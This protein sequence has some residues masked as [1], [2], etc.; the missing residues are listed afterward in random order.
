MMLLYCISSRKNILSLLGPRFEV[1]LRIRFILQT[2]AMTTNAVMSTSSGT[3]PAIKNLPLLFIEEL[4]TAYS[5]SSSFVTLL[6]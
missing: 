5:M 6:S 4:F 1:S 3:T 2:V